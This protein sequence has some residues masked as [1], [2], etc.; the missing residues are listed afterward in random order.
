MWRQRSRQLWIKERDHNTR[1]FHVVTTSRRK[2]NYIQ[3]LTDSSGQEEQG[4][5]LHAHVIQFDSHLFSTES[6]GGFNDN[7]NFDSSKVNPAMNGQLLY[8]YSADEIFLA[9]KQMHPIKALGLDGLPLLFF[10][11]YCGVVGGSVQQI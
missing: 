7:L 10:Q 6:G 11:K 4:C 8:S 5:A 3:L 1:Y 9:V 2:N